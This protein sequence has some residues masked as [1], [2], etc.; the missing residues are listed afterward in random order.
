MW[1]KLLEFDELEDKSCRDGLARAK[2]GE[3]KPADLAWVISHWANPETISV[4]LMIELLDSNDYEVRYSCALALGK[5]GDPLAIP[6]LAR[7]LESDDDYDV[8]RACAWALGELGDHSS[9]P[10]LTQVLGSDKNCFVRG[11]CERALS[12]IED[13]QAKEG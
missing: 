12:K 2:E 9:I 11:E 10:A 5:I 6:A 13:K 1:T 7:V 4:E 8:R 3:Y